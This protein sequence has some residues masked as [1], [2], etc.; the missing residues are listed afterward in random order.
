MYLNYPEGRAGYWRK[1]GHVDAMET[2]VVANRKRSEGARTAAALHYGAEQGK[3]F[4][5]E[6]AG[7]LGSRPK[8]RRARSSW[9]SHAG[10]RRG[11]Q[12]PRE[13]CCGRPAP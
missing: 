5:L 3:E 8:R 13:A 9:R 7:L 6:T 11:H 2:V 10:S 12:A 4:L 1:N